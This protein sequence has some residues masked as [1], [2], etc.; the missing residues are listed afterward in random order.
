M[1]HQYGIDVNNLEKFIITPETDTLVS[2]PEYKLERLAI[3]HGGS[4]DLTIGKDREATVFVE[5]GSV[6]LAGISLESQE[7]I[8]LS[9][10]SKN[11]FTAA[12]DSILYVFYGQPSTGKYLEKFQP[13]DYRDKYW[14]NIQTIVSKEYAAK[15]LFVRKGQYASL[16]F[17]CNK[18]ESYYIHSGK[19]LLRL[20]A[21]R[22][23][24]NFFEL[25]QGTATITPPGLMHQRGGVEDTVII[26]ISTKDEDSDS[27]LVEDGR[28]HVMPRLATLINSAQTYKGRICFDIDGVLRTQTKGDYENAKAIPDAINLVNKL[29]GEGYHITLYT[30]SFMGRSKNDQRAAYEAGFAFNKEQLASWGVKY[31]ELFMGKPP[32]DILIDDRAL[33]FNPDWALIEKAIRSKV[34]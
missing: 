12:S 29:Y 9:P 19:L 21:G 24:D 26:E 3:K 11:K 18:L 8:T 1:I 27:Y 16:E 30:S 31:H 28:K 13:T 14:G 25:F 17:H 20:R 4:Y 6:T 32:T 7:I 33:F 5:E 15:R 2:L 34:K 10:E 22:G 23:E